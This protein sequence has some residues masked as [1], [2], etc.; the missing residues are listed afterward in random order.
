L[1]A[2]R[3]RNAQEPDQDVANTSA[4]EDSNLK[5]SKN[6]VGRKLL[7]ASVGLATTSYVACAEDAPTA[8]NLL[9]PPIEEDAARPHPDAKLPLPSRDAAPDELGPVGNLMPPPPIDA[10]EDE[11][12]DNASDAAGD[13]TKDTQADGLDAPPD[14]LHP[15][16]GNLMPPPQ[17]DAAPDTKGAKK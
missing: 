9:A 15:P 17:P 2:S 4:V 7:I 11:P 5:L 14:L 3:G 16:V 1:A 10:A 13:A 6:L 12:A 8:G